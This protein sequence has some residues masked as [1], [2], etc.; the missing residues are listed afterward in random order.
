MQFPPQQE[1]QEVQETRIRQAEE[2]REEL[3]VPQ[4]VLAP[5]RL[6]PLPAWELREAEEEAPVQ[7]GVLVAS[8]EEV[9]VEAAQPMA[10]RLAR[11][12]REAGAR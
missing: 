6:Q 3:Q 10:V 4:A 2:E 9:V 1:G 11:E 5:M 8:Q 12:A 7:T